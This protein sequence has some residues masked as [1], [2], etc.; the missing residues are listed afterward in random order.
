MVKI[1]K[2][3]S[4]L[5][6]EKSVAIIKVTLKGYISM[7]MCHMK[8]YNIS[9]DRLDQG[10]SNELSYVFIAILRELLEPKYDKMSKHCDTFFH[11][12]I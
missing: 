7:D 6:N 2:N 4:P 11:H 3:S 1:N 5:K 10:L 9:F 8:T 12:C